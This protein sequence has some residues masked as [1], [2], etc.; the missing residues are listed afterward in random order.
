ML[1]VPVSPETVLREVQDQLGD[2]PLSLAGLFQAGERLANAAPLLRR[3]G[4]VACQRIAVLGAAT[5]DYLSRAIAC[6]VAQEG[7]FPVIHQTP[8]GTYVQEALNPASGLHAFAPDLAVI[9]PEARDLTDGLAIG[10]T[11]AEVAE[12]VRARAGTFERIWDSLAARGCRI[13]QHLLVPPVERFAGVAERLTPASPT[14]LIRHLNDA[15]LAAGRGRVQFVDLE[16][17]AANVGTRRWAA[18]G[19]WYGRDSASTSGSCPTTCLPSEAPGAPPTR[20]RRRRLSS[21][22]TTRCGA[23]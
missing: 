15:L 22:S 21:I 11:A 2:E 3:D 23:A 8:F 12:A 18:G 1:D 7:V 14:N 13:V 5:T 9:A 20:G 17:L 4:E 10:A 16:R 19:F 6:G